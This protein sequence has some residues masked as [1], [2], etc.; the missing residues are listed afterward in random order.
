MSFSIGVN[1]L[2]K[3]EEELAHCLEDIETGRKMCHG[4]A[5]TYS[6]VDDPQHIIHVVPEK[7]QH[8][9][10]QAKELS[11]EKLVPPIRVVKTCEGKTFT[12]TDVAYPAT[13]IIA[14]AVGG[15]VLIRDKGVDRLARMPQKYQMSIVELCTRLIETG[16]V[17]NHC[18]L[19]SIGFTE[20]G[21]RFIDLEGMKTC[22]FYTGKEKLFALAFC[23]L[24]LL[25]RVPSDEI[26]STVIFKVAMAAI[27]GSHFWG[28]ELEHRHVFLKDVAT[29]FP[30]K[31]V[32]G[33]ASRSR[34]MTEANS[35]I[36]LAVMY[37][38]A[39]LTTKTRQN[40]FILSEL[41]RLRN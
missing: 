2:P 16:R 30:L 18:T 3:D 25:E 22:K 27:S 33:F 41:Q 23:L 15:F 10:S 32:H 38:A 9:I 39:I 37:Y 1:H 6:L 26:E 34:A 40:D 7:S 19:S 35:D 12:V 13:S 29:R 31:E 21:A 20:E 4:S 28:E 36:F 17:H 11:E 14:S 24:Q 5:C 8:E